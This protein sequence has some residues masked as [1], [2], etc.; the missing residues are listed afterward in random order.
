MLGLAGGAGTKCLVALGL[1]GGAGTL[2]AA[3]T[4][5]LQAAGATG[6]PWSSKAGWSTAVQELDPFMRGVDGKEQLVKLAYLAAFSPIC[7]PAAGGAVP[8]LE[9][10]ASR[11]GTVG[12]G[13]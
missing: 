5:S 9:G 10:G 6:R 8:L 7:V 2:C 12:E 4:D 3:G 11:R 13:C 1:A